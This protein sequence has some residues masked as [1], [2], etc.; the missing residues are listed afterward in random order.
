[1]KL[2]YIII[3]FGILFQSHNVVAQIIGDLIS[4]AGTIVSGLG[5]QIGNLIPTADE[6]AN[7]SIQFLV[8]LPEVAIFGALNR[9]CKFLEK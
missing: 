3:L 8:G 7:A 2:F 9:L 6:L 1:M 5:M 4:S